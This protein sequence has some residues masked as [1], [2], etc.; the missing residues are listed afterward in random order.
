M[1]R[2]LGLEDLYTIAVPGEPAI[3]PDGARVVY[4][5]RTVDR[6]ADRNRRCLWL[7]ED[8]REAIQLTRGGGDS[9]PAWSPDGRWIAFLRAQDG[10]AQVWLLAAAG[11]EP[12]RLTTLPLAAGAPVWSPDGTR[13]AFAAPVDLDADPG[14]DEAARKRRTNAPVRTERLVY[15]ADGTGLLRGMRSHLFVVQVPD[16]ELRRLTWGDWH[17]SRPAWSPDGRHLAWS[18]EMGPDADLHPASAAYVLD[19]EAPAGG[20]RAVGPIDGLAGPVTWTG[21][22]SALLVVGRPDVAD[23]PSGLRRVPLAG[24][25]VRDL[26]APLD[27]NVM[28]GG[29]A[30][31]GGLPQVA[32]DGRTVLF[33]ARDR[34]RTHLYAV[35]AEG[36]QPRKLIGGD[37]VV[38]GLSVAPAADRF[39]VVTTRPDTFGEIALASLADPSPRVVTRHMIPE[40]ELFAGVDREFPIADGGRVHGWLLRDP[41]AGGARP[42]LLDIH[43]GPH[44]AWSGVADTMHLYHQELVARGW[45]VLTLNP[46]ASDGYGAAFWTATHGAW[47]AADERDFLEPLDQLVAEGVAD[48]D[49]LA[50]AGYSYGGFMTCHL[51]GVTDRFRA[52]VTGGVVSNLASLFGTSDAGLSL[53]R[54][55]L[56][57]APHEDPELFRRLSP[58][59]R[60]D[61]VTTPTLILQGLADDRTDAGQA[62]EWFAALRSR[63]IPTRMVLYPGEAHVF[64]DGG[65]P[66][67][68]LDFNRRILDWL[69]EHVD[70]AGPALDAAHWGRRLAELAD[71]HS[72]PGAALGILRMG[73]HGDE[74]VEVATGV[75]NLDT[76]VEATPG[77]LFQLGSITK[78]WTTTLV[79]GLVDEGRLDLDRPVADYL[80]GLTLGSPETAARVT[81]RHLLTHTSGVDG[82][83]F[84]D[85]GRGDDCVERYVDLLAGVPVNHDPG[86]TFSYCNAGFIL[87]GR[88][89]EKLTG[90]TWDEALRERLLK[91]LGLEHTVTLPEDA[92][93]FRTALGHV[94]DPPRPA[95]RWHLPRSVGPAGVISATVADT[96]AFARMHLAGGVAPDG[97][98]VLSEDSVQA[99]Q[100][101]QTDVPD[102]LTKGDSWGLGWMRFGWGGLRL[103]GHDGNTIGQSAFLRLLPARSL[104]VTLLTNGGHTEDLYHD[105]VGE[106]FSELAGIAPPPPPEPSGEVGPDASEWLGTYERV[107]LR[108]EVLQRDGGLMLRMT[109][110]TPNMG[111]E[112]PEPP[113]EYDLRPV[114]DRLYVIRAPGTRSWAPVV[115]YTLA[116]GSRRLHHHLRSSPLTV[117]VQGQD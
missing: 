70:A 96:L 54:L 11:G 101:H 71:R 113:Q 107:G 50:V 13:L 112:E 109:D 34:G 27:R 23:G 87:A 104:A 78:V 64:I 41:D 15:K 81:M 98:R 8:G 30:Y 3:S 33:C 105:L 52:A 24:G 5:L 10:P 72:V 67:H 36:G 20:P 60:V 117:P 25:E 26:A 45:N 59:T 46:R 85:T 62:E 48:R 116:D 103:I 106:V 51:T 56:G 57:A 95:P 93:R 29:P 73:A 92:L 66:S 58:I 91:P 55:E 76:G 99:M 19:L 40:V 9:A 68:R 47:G 16:G 82:D 22:G 39:A 97:T 102:T 75:L 2:R 18:A 35:D 65:S 110:T 4:V 114:R 6:E 63:R 84:D 69:A 94:G 32:S 90:M 21:D 74:T 43:G 44:N 7:A 53:S 28:P 42:L 17:A 79:M 61:R 12:R 49:H 83:F 100:D 1:G 88:V 80:P 89:V 31:P 38:A 86:A 77:S 108:T 37:T 111:E 115:F 14:E